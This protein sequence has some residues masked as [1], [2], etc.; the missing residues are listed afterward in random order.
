M[1]AEIFLF[2]QDLD[3][4][5]VLAGTSNGYRKL[6]TGAEADRSTISTRNIEIKRLKA[7]LF[8]FI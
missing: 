7:K 3:R 1:G 8:C 5:W 6:L 4:L 2:P